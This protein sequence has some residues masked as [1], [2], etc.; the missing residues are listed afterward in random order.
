MTVE[1]STPNSVSVPNDLFS[2]VNLSAATLH[3]PSGTKALYE[4]HPVWGLF[5]TIDDGTPAYSLSVL[6]DSLGFVASGE[7]QSFAIISDTDWTVSSDVSWLA[8]SQ[9]S[10]SN[11]AA[12]TVFSGL[13]RRLAMTACA[14]VVAVSS[15]V[16][17]RDESIQ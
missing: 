4:V 17:A 12:I 5:G 6:P 7:Q 1:W 2:G 3:V 15:P 14:A 9:A 13:L 11:N 10:G 8:F 16:I